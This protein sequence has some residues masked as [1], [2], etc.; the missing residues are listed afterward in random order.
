MGQ[1]LVRLLSALRLLQFLPHSSLDP[2]HARD[3]VW[4]YRSRLGTG[5]ITS[6]GSDTLDQLNRLYYGDNLTVLRNDIQ[7]E[8]VDLVYVDPPFNSQSNYNVLFRGPAG[9][10]SHAQIE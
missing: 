1:P 6:L 10:Q 2:R 5:L 8:S 4:T 9:E 7:R 3:G